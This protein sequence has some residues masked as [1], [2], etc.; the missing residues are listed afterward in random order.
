MSST[1]KKQPQWR[2]SRVNIPVYDYRVYHL[3]TWERIGY[4]VVAFAVAGAVGY[5]LF[6]GLAADPEGEPTSATRVLDAIAVALPGVLGARY[7]LRLRSEQIHQKNVK[8]LERQFRDV[9]DSLN[10]SLSAGGTVIQA[11]QTARDDLEKQYSADAPMVS[12]L[13]VIIAGFHNSVRIEEMV[14]DLGARS[15]SQDIE[16]FSEVFTIAYTKGAD[17]KQA[18][19]NSHLVLAEKMSIAEEIET[20]L[21]ASKNEAFIMV[22][23]P[24]VLVGMLKTGGGSFAEALRTPVGVV[25]TLVAVTLFVASYAL[26]RK[27]MTIKF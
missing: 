9:L 19:R 23:I 7:F 26:A 5:L 4:F 24:I 2:P 16:S 12:E 6:G 21:V 1:R 27:I 25:C 20:S 15:G 10:S 11:F 22:V 14:E 8:N 18:V 3:T 13:N 17:M